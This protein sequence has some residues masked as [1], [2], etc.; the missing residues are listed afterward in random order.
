M[1][2][3]QDHMSTLV[4]G[5]STA[6]GSATAAHLP[7]K[8]GGT[9]GP[10]SQLAESSEEI[11]LLDLLLTSQMPTVFARRGVHPTSKSRRGRASHRLLSL[12]MGV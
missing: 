4:I 6:S 5:V 1:L 11:L 9:G 3:G 8:L 7:W 12:W 10:R 2:W